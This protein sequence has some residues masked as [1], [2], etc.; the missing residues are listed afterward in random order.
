MGGQL[1]QAICIAGTPLLVDVTGFR[2]SYP[3]RG[4][5][6]ATPKDRYEMHAYLGGDQPFGAARIQLEG[7]F[8]AVSLGVPGGLTSGPG[9]ALSM[10]W[11]RGAVR[12]FVRSRN[13]LRQPSAS[14]VFG[15]G[16]QVKALDTPT[17]SDSAFQGRSAVDEIGVSLRLGWLSLFGSVAA[18]RLSEG[19]VRLLDESADTLSVVRYEGTRSR[20]SA[21]LGLGMREFS[22]RGLYMWAR[23][24]ASTTEGDQSDLDARIAQSIPEAFAAAAVG[25]RGVLFQGDLDGDLSVRVRGW[26]EHRGLRFHPETGL[27]ALPALDSRPME[28]SLA[29]DIVGMAHIRA[30]TITLSLENALSGSVQFP[31]NQLVPDYPYPE[32]RLRFSVFWPILD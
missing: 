23:A 15:F 20:S 4:G 27:L 7:G 24:T 8:S 25:L 32:R 1:Q 19:V 30:A 16:S 11:E 5:W 21:T 18:T 13:A 14:D 3:A 22:R 28:Q 12:P 10:E 26:T 29:L 9:Y 6:N 31:G 2:D 17:D